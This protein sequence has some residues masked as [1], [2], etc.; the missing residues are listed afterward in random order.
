MQARFRQIC[1][2]VAGADLF[3]DG[4]LRAPGVQAFEQCF[5]KGVGVL[6]L[7]GVPHV[8]K[9]DQC[10]VRNAAC[11]LPAQFGI[12]ADSGS[13]FGRYEVLA[14]RRRVTLAATPDS[15]VI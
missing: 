11:G 1:K 13:D 14:D 10:G 2:A 3:A 7:W 12:I 4:L 5:V 15:V 9:F 8:G 6:Y